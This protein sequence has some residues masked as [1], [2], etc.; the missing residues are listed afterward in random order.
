MIPQKERTLEHYESIGA[1]VSVVNYLFTKLV[2]E[3]GKVLYAKDSDGL[4]KT[5]NKLSHYQSIMEDQMFRDFPELSND[6]LDVFYGGLSSGR[7]TNVSVRHLLLILSWLNQAKSIV[8]NSIKNCKEINITISSNINDVDFSNRVKNTLN[9][10]GRFL[11]MDKLLDAYCASDILEGTNNE[12]PRL[13]SVKNLGRKGI[14]EI[15]E[16]LT[17]YHFI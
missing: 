15:E 12:T 8:E 9:R 5:N 14:Q 7:C 3:G 2:V 16:V 13:L 10:D 11:T 6:Y 1:L 4:A 17:K